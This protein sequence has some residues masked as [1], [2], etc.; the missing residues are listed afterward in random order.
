MARSPATRRFSI[1]TTRLSYLLILAP[2]FFMQLSCAQT[3]IRPFARTSQ[4]NLPAPARILI[5]DFAVSD[6]AVTEYQGILRQKPS[7]RDPLL[8]Q[9][10]LADGA[11]ETLTAH[12]TVGLRRLGLTVERVQ[13]GAPVNPGDVIVDGRFVTVNEGNPLRRIV[14]G[15]GSGASNLDTQVRLLRAGQRQ[16]LLEFATRAD[17]GRVPGA[18]AT[19]PAGVAAPTAVSTAMAAGTVVHTGLHGDSSNVG[20]M[21]EASAEQAVRYLSEFFANQGWIKAAQVRRAQLGH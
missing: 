14:I 13:R 20:H 8:R 5:Y 11:A 1:S 7:T 3:S 21:A 9:R 10:A 19:L 6:A 15:F 4:K 16:P 12:L 2:V 17:S 18:L